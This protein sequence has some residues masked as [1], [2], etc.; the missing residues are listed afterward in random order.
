MC[1]CGGSCGGA[2]GC[3]GA[4]DGRWNGAGASSWSMPAQTGWGAEDA[5]PDAPA[6]VAPVAMGYR[7]PAQPREHHG[8][9]WL[10]VAAAVVFWLGRHSA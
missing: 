5:P 7:A 4:S 3:A 10:L 8:W 9:L 6:T 2:A 1:G